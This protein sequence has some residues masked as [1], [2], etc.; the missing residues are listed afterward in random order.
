[1][2]DRSIVIHGH[3]YQPPRENPWIEEIEVQDS[4]APYHDWNARITAECYA[5]NSAARIVGGDGG[6]IDIINNFSRISFNVGPTLLADLERRAPTVYR[7]ILEADRQSA[8][9]RGGHGNAIAQVYNHMILPLASPRDEVTQV[10]WGIR[11]FQR[12]FGRDPRGMW[13]AECGVDLDTLRVLADEGIQFT[14]LGQQQGRRHRRIDGHGGA[15]TAGIDPRRPYRVMLGGD[16]SIV[17]FFYDGAVAHDLSF[18]NALRD[19]DSFVDRLLGAF[20]G[21]E[22]GLVNV[23]TDGETFGH[24]RAF[25]DMVLAA[26]IERIE[27]E[28]P[29]TL[30]NYAEYL[31]GHPPEHVAE[32]HEPSAWS[33]AHGVAR[34]CDDC[35]CSTSARDGWNQRWRR[36]L[37]DALDELSGRL[38][39]AFERR[40]RPLFEDPWR[41]RDAY[42]DVLLDRSTEN[43]DAFLAQHA[44]RTLD[45]AERV[46]ALKLLEMQRHAMLMFTS[47]GWF[48]GELS[49]PEGVQ[50]LK[51]A[52]R[53]IQLAR[54]VDPQLD[55]LDERFHAALGRARSNV[56]EAGDGARILDQRVRPSVVNL[57]GVVA[58][59]AISSLFQSYPPRGRLFCYRY[60]ADERIKRTRG[61]VTLAVGQAHLSSDVTGETTHACFAVLHF[62]GHDVRCAVAGI[63]DPGWYREARDELLAAFEEESISDVVRALDRRFP[64]REYA[65]S[66]LFLDERRKIVASIVGRVLTQ[67]RDQ[68]FRVF[69]ENRPL[70]RFL[71]DADIPV[72]GPLRAAAD[73]AL[74]A[75]LQSLVGDARYGS[76][77]WDHVIAE[78]HRIHEE[79]GALGAVLDTADA[80]RLIEARILDEAMALSVAPRRETTKAILAYLDLAG[81]LGLKPDLWEAQ[82]LFW[83]LTLEGPRGPDADTQLLVRL[84]ERLGFDRSG[85]ETLWRRRAGA[86]VAQ[87]SA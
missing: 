41:A 71:V 4:A 11:D 36:P 10:R 79:A 38:A 24:H 44:R 87:D 17:V 58:H 86:P 1:V 80:R 48:F 52:A 46:T 61:P 82:N 51:Y 33:C 12:R 64:G 81:A 45:G 34:W 16:R 39:S 27:R 3:F 67:R 40:G 32:L 77:R 2:P 5:P 59:Y 85:M 8:R 60:E 37:R 18:G 20:G 6:V 42:I 66:D 14:I 73:Y 30:T 15:W 13:L 76:S 74:S 68:L 54:E 50:I 29:A 9:E 78:L 43:V 53:A 72:P 56:P 25:G 21:E 55:D 28:R 57:G 62:G 35:G 49:G 83:T 19:R 69:E 7:K 75:R 84:G 70:L 26:A 31:A 23:A 22:H 65:L 63:T 47:C